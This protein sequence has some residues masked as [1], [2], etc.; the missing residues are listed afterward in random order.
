MNRRSVYLVAGAAIVIF[1]LM[2]FYASYQLL[3]IQRT[4]SSFTG[5]DMLWNV[6]QTA[7]EIGRLSDAVRA[8]EQ[9][10]NSDEIDLRLQLLHSRVQILSD[11]PQHAFY[12]EIKGEKHLVV[13]KNII[14]NFEEARN[15]GQLSSRQLHEILVPALDEMALL[16][17]KTMLAQREKTGAQIDKQLHTIYLIMTSIAGLLLAGGTISW[18]LIT[19]IRALHAAQSKLYD[20]NEKLEITIQLRTDELQQALAN[21]R[22]TNAIYKNFLSTVSHQFRTPIAIIDMIAQRFVR[23]PNDI[24]SAILVER[25][26]RI[27]RAVKQLTLIMDS[28]I[29]NDRLAETGL[30]LLVAQFDFKHLVG[31]ICAYHMEIYPKRKVNFISAEKEFLIVGDATLLE[32]I[33]VNLLSN[34]EKYSPKSMP[35]NVTLSCDAN[36]VLFTVTDFGIGIPDSD[37]SM[38]FQR[39]FRAS[40]VLHLT[41]SGLGLSLSASLAQLH[42]GVINCDS[43]VG[44][45]STFE[46]SLPINGTSDE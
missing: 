33:L 45:G 16:S 2:L 5:E 39:F 34:A 13:L 41:G 22:K 38:I 28:T 15:S 37:R 11:N 20:Y 27:R 14:N 17:N 3:T 44:I 9:I 21:E 23:R 29:N 46:L 6:T 30:K 42:G 35:I 19:N 1:A 4:L 12:V 32:Q 8:T 7:R 25:T 36:R 31:K 10:S 24:T 40:N 18:L 26:L 43:E